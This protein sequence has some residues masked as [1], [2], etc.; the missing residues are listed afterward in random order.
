MDAMTFLR[1]N[2]PL[3]A[4][5]SDEDLAHLAEQSRLLAFKAG[6]TVVLKGTTVDGLHVLV[7]GAAEVCAKVPN[8]GVV[9]VATLAPGDCCGETSIV[10]M[11]VANATV[12]AL[13]DS[14]RVLLIPQEAFRRVLQ[15]DEAFAVRVN[16][17]IRDRRS[18]SG[19][20]A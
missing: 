3:F 13:E 12:K 8:K 7:S 18:P 9:R 2:A 17:L 19:V 6:Q 10:E 14:T 15:R 5:L 4:G 11:G 20:P 1:E 16:T